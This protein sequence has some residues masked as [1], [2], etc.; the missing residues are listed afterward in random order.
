MYIF[1][2][3]KSISSFELLLLPSA[4][5]SQVDGGHAVAE[6]HALSPFATARADGAQE[7]GVDAA[8]HVDLPPVFVAAVRVAQRG[9]QGL[10]DVAICGGRIRTM[11][12]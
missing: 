3:P 10:A 1:L 8:P 5:S 9:H 7:V 6:I 2:C 11:Q 12:E 4:I